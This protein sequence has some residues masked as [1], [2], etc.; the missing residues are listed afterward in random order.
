MFSSLLSKVNV[1]SFFKPE[2]IRP[3]NAISIAANLS[4]DINCSGQKILGRAS[5]SNRKVV[6]G[7]PQYT[8]FYENNLGGRYQGLVK[9]ADKK[10]QFRMKVIGKN[11]V[12]TGTGSFNSSYTR[13][14]GTTSDNCSFIAFTDGR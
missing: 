11:I 12:A 2:P 10:F 1:P 8:L 14:K 7:K 9:I 13:L 6:A 5:F 3:K 4:F